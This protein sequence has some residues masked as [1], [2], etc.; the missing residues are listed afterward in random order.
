MTS[1]ALRQ[2]TE[3]FAWEMHLASRPW[4]FRLEEIEVETHVFQG[5][6]DRATPPAMGRYL[7][8]KSLGIQWSAA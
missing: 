6:E 8:A 5:A 1:E 7:T 4:G 3:G 2:G